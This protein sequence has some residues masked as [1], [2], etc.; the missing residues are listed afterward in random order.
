MIKIFN[1]FYAFK[2]KNYRKKKDKGT[3]MIQKRVNIFKENSLKTF[4]NKKNFS[5]FSVL[6]W[7]RIIHTDIFVYRDHIGKEIIF[8]SR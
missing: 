3:K 7:N 5:V 2:H 4:Q 8:H 6:E 1:V